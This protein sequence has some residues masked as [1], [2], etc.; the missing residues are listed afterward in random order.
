MVENLQTKSKKPR[1]QETKKPR[2][3]ETKKS[4]NHLFL[5]LSPLLC[6]AL[7][8]HFTSAPMD[9]FP[10]GAHT[11]YVFFAGCLPNKEQKKQTKA[12]TEFEKK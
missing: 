10:F 9:F 6:F 11:W 12:T 8:S 7:F 5:V 1:N 4:R 3:Q 2:N